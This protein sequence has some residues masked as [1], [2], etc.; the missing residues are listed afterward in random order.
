MCSKQFFN[1]SAL[2]TNLNYNNNCSLVVWERSHEVIPLILSTQPH[3]PNQGQVLP[4][5][6]GCLV[7]IAQPSLLFVINSSWPQQ[8]I[9][10]KIKITNH[11]FV[12]L[13]RAEQVILHFG[14]S[15][16]A[17]LR[18]VDVAAFL[19]PTLAFRLLFP[20]LTCSTFSF[21]FKDLLTAEMYLLPELEGALL[22][23]NP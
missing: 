4:P 10:G 13:K 18:R 3:P 6:F 12:M 22:E 1:D 15:V 8:V 21:V 2:K 16:C 19:F 14:F 11:F 9:N 5:W 20:D 23:C 7:I 17:L